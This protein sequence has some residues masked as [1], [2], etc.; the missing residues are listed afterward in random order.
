MYAGFTVVISFDAVFT[1]NPISSVI[2]CVYTNFCLYTLCIIQRTT[3][4]ILHVSSVQH[5][6][7]LTFYQYSVEGHQQFVKNGGF[8]QADEYTA[9]TCQ[10]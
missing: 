3:Y 1:D 7:L 6:L 2:G 8:F 4:K 9:G 10:K 5:V